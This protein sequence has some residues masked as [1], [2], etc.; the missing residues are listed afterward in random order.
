MV[1]GN[2]LTPRKKKTIEILHQEGYNNANIARRVG[3][4]RS[5]VSRNLKKLL[6]HGSM[7][8]KRRSGRPR[9]SSQRSDAVLRRIC[10]KSR[11]LTSRQLAVEWRE[12]TGTLVSSS[13]VRQRLLSMGLRARRAKKKPI[14][15]RAMRLKRLQ[16]AKTHQNWT[17]ERWSNVIFSDESRFCTISDAPQLVRRLSSESL[18]PECLQRTTKYPP[19]VMVWGCFSSKGYG[20]I[21]F[22][23]KTMNSDVYKQVLDT[24]LF[25]TVQDQFGDD[26]NWIFQQDSAPCH[27]SKK[28]KEFF[29]EHNI[30]VLDW[31]GNSP[32]LN[33]IENLWYIMAKKVQARHPK[34]KRDLKEAVI[35]VWN[36]ELTTELGQSL[37]ESMPRR[38]SAVIKSRGGVT[39]Y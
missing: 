1:K 4:S 21:E 6:D 15:S 31:P 23:E 19:S 16:W 2:E 22:V 20:R 30:T 8:N 7:D 11:F 33:P 18:R 36:H 5:A 17:A 28:M 24:K 13:L 14:L 38:C 12:S 34:N 3:C 9:L 10:K 37:I 25:R 27:T 39:K 35:H 32:D 26:R 29:T